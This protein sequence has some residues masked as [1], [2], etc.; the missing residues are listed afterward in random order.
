MLQLVALII[1]V[2]PSDSII[3][4]VFFSVHNN[5]NALVYSKP[6]CFSIDCF[7]IST[8]TDL[9]SAACRASDVIGGKTIFF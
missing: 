8:T 4:H 2:L 6:K 7:L 5:F 3:I 9:Q 1:S